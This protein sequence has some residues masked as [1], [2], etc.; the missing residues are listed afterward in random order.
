MRHL[1]TVFSGP[2]LVRPMPRH[3]PNTKCVVDGKQF[4]TLSEAAEE[5]TRALN[6]TPPWNGDL[7]AFDDYLYGGMGTP[8]APFGLVWR[9][10]DLSKQRLGYPETIRWFEDHLKTCHASNVASMQQRLEEARQLRGP[11]LFDWLLEIFQK[12]PDIELILE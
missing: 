2:L 1:I 7:D 5:F 4:T 12:H 6:L 3:V 9:H 10:S 11:T 8:D